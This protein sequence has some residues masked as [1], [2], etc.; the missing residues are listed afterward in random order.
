[1]LLSRFSLPSL[2]IEIEFKV[3]RKPSSNIRKSISGIRFLL[4]LDATNLKVF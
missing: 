1:M 2:K 3:G 4:S